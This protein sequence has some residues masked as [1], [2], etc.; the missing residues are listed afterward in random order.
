MVNVETPVRLSDVASYFDANISCDVLAMDSFNPD[1]QM[2]VFPLR[3]EAMVIML[4]TSGSGRVHIDMTSHELQRGSLLVVQPQNFVQGF[5]R[6]DEF[7]SRTVMCSPRVVETLLP[8]LTSMLPIIMQHRLEP[9]L[10][11]T[12]DELTAMLAF[13]TFVKLKLD[14]PE[15]PY[16]SQKVLCMLQAA[17]YEM[18]DIRMSHLKVREQ[19][20]SRR[21]EI[22]ARFILSICENYHTERHVSFYARQLCITSKHLSSVVKET[23]GR[24]AGEWIDHYVVM[25][26]KMLLASTDMTVQEISMRLNFA[27]QSFFGKYFKHHTGQSPTEY[28]RDILKQSK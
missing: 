26:A 24:T 9:V 21:E 13:Y 11:L 18:M 14:G 28:R 4:C 22:M 6:D 27:N 1:P 5:E 7:S 19:P 2:E 23:S 20:Q 10:Q 15:T 16:R 25:E 3:I 12:D 8:K 17:L